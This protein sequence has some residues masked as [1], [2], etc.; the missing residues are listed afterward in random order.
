VIEC[1]KIDE[2]NKEKKVASKKLT[3]GIDDKFA[4]VFKASDLFT[5]YEK[6]KNELFI[7]VRKNYLNLYYNCDS[8][9]KVVY[10]Q[11]EI[12]CAIDRYY[13]DGKHYKSDDKRK[14]AC[15]APCEIYT[16]YDTI[17]LNAGKK[18]TDEKNAQA[19][20]VILNN[21]N[22]KSNWFCLDVEWKKAF[23]DKQQR[24]DAGFNGRF[25]IIAISKKT[26]HIVA[27][28][29]LKYGA[30][31]IGGKSGIYKHIEDFKKYQDKRYFD[32]PAGNAHKKEIADI[33]ES[34]KMLGVNV[35]K[36]LQNVTPNDITGPEFY[37]ITLDNNGKTLKHD[38]PKQ[39]MAAYLF[40]DKRWGCKELSPGP[41]VEEKFGDVTKKT[42][43]LN[44]AF[45]FSQQKLG[46]LNIN[47][48]IDGNYD[49]R[50]LPT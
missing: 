19:M 32:D 36:K 38:I 4:D 14:N 28:I 37:V 6:Y 34:Y 29:E 7:G 31:A 50:I 33:I 35:P 12:S 8:I 2:N 49:E 40:K 16:Q 39:T 43:K 10:K 23:D 5:L 22:E 30:K 18:N 3:R 1:R 15:V 20:L 42:N 46:N 24:S 41:K 48:I 25:D 45:L 17:K 21:S 13:L 27:V 9:A 11:G 26:P 44:V 47:D